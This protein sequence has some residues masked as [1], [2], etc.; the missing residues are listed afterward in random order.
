MLE[1]KDFA[2]V[3]F[4]GKINTLLATRNRDTEFC[5]MLKRC[6]TSTVTGME[7][8]LKQRVPACSEV[9]ELP[10]QVSYNRKASRANS[11]LNSKWSH[12]HAMSSFRHFSPKGVFGT[13]KPHV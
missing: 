12:L 10:D 9:S 2:Y 5:T 13:K 1:F 3:V 8:E 7:M 11:I 4:L 6:P